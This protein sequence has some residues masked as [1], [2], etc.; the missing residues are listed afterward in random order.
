MLAP[1]NG[2]I[3]FPVSKFK[4]LGKNSKHFTL[5]VTNHLSILDQS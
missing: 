1:I 4:S 5:I 2:Q 3:F